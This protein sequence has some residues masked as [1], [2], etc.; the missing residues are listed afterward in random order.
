M[1]MLLWFTIEIHHTNIKSVVISN[2]FKSGMFSGLPPQTQNMTVA[3]EI[4]AMNSKTSA[5]RRD[6]Y[7][8]LRHDFLLDSFGT[9]WFLPLVLA[10]GNLL[11][12][13]VNPY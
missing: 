12:S 8:T 5:M 13:Y 1:L 7:S 6:R 3:S 9:P 2:L 11:S 4:S 10:F